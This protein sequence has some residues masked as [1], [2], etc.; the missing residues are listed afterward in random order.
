MAFIPPQGNQTVMVDNSNN[1]VYPAGFNRISVNQA[2]IAGNNFTSVPS[3]IDPE[4]ATMAQLPSVASVVNYVADVVE[5][6]SSGLIPAIQDDIEML[7]Q[8]KA[9]VGEFYFKNNGILSTSSPMQINGAFTCIW[10]TT[11]GANVYGGSTPT[12]RKGWVYTFPYQKSGTNKGFCL[13]MDDAYMGFYFRYL[14]SNGEVIQISITKT[15]IQYYDGKPHTYAFIFNGSNN[16]RL[17]I[18]NVEEFTDVVTDFAPF[19]TSHPL[20]IT[21]PNQ[22]CSRIKWFNFDMSTN[23]A[24]YTIA[25]YISGKDESPLLN[26]SNPTQDWHSMQ[27]GFS[28]DASTGK[29]TMTNTSTVNAYPFALGTLLPGVTYKIKVNGSILN[30][31]GTQAIRLY[32]PT[33]K[34]TMTRT[35]IT[36]DET[37]IAEYAQNVAYL[38]VTDGNEWNVEIT[39]VCNANSTNSNTYLIADAVDTSRENYFYFSAEKIGSLLSLDDYS[40]KVGA[41]QIVP[42]VSSNNNDATIT[43]S[44]YGSKDN[45]ISK[46]AQLFYQS[47]QG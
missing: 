1:I 13:A 12:Q 32:L 6:G 35:N 19:T 23:D 30:A 28:R 17:L 41:T 37:T 39:F 34:Y 5:G 42:D 26:Q 21:S 7:G 2:T 20:S 10:T 44:I 38:F 4:N 22:T 29:I 8:E 43:G 25:D 18:D 3:E 33:D 46:M 15:K 16:V 14:N 45:S 40:I 11:R 27:T 24:I 9:N 47:Q 31:S 36:T